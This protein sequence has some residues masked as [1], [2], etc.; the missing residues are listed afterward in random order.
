MKHTIK[1][2]LKLLVLPLMLASCN[3][4]GSDSSFKLYKTEPTSSGNFEKIAESATS[5]N[6]VY[7]TR[8]YTDNRSGKDVT[9]NNTDIKMKTADKE[10]T[11]LYFVNNTH[12]ESSGSSSSYY[13]G[14]KSETKVVKPNEESEYS[15]SLGTITVA[16]EVNG[17]SSSS[18]DIT[19]KGTTLKLY[20]QN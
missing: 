6:E 15:T 7:I 3:L 19:Y 10:Y 13:I 11:A 1:Q 8:F 14:E 16:F 18:Y 4:S 2:S 5:S 17:D 9:L 20:G 12:S